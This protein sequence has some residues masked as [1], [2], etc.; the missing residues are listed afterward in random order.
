MKA[1]LYRPKQYRI[2]WDT[3]LYWDDIHTGVWFL[4]GILL[5]PCAVL[6]MLLT[7]RPY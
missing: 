4:V 2:D 7:K 3:E 5:L 1:A 6:G